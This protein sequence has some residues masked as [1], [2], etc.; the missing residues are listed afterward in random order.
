MRSANRSVLAEGRLPGG[1]TSS[2][3]VELT[4]LEAGLGIDFPYLCSGDT[5]GLKL[6]S[7]FMLKRYKRV[8]D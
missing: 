3:Q 1:Q 5:L 8:R 2:R 4:P 7:N 6:P